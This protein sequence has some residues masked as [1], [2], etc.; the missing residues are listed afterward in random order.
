MSA[1]GFYNLTAQT[2]PWSVPNKWGTASALN[3]N[4]IPTIDGVKL[5]IGDYIG[6]FND[7]GQCFGLSE[8]K[9]T[10]VIVKVLGSNS[11]SVSTDGL[12]NGEKYNIKIWLSKENCIVENITNVKSD[13]SL[14]YS[15]TRNNTIS[16]LNFQKTG[17]TYPKTEFCLNNESFS[18]TI[19]QSLDDLS[20]SSGTGLNLDITTGKIIPQ[21]SIAGNYAVSV[22]SKYC[23]TN[24]T[25]S[26][27][28]NELPKIE[29][30]PDTFICG[31]KLTLTLPITEGVIA[32]SDGGNGNQLDVTESR[33]LSYTITNS[34]GCTNS[35]TIKVLKMAIAN[36]DFTVNKADCYQKGALNITNEAITNGKPPYNYKLT[37]LLDKT[38]TDNISNI[39]EGIYSIDVVNS[40]GCALK[41]NKTLVVEKDCLN[42]KPVFTPNEDG[43]DDRYF[44]NLEGNIRIFDRGGIIK[45][46]L[47]GPCYFNGLDSNGHPLPMGT[48]LVV[49]QNG[50]NITLTIVR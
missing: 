35:D 3:I 42:D 44:L 38:E 9:D 49:S 2:V 18:P 34:Q 30:I 4:C 47:T 29:H 26:V 19:S 20:F 45:R 28:L 27:I 23:L 11:V 32:W 16:S 50:K 15:A 22:N 24:K 12:R 8:W 6:V 41:H 31:E 10:S 40:N 43:M 7:S 46:K 5:S 36:L 39:Q 48:Y 13:T 14:I 33:T 37:N 25:L 21:K 1:F 17:I